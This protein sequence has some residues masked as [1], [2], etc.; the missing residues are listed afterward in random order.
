MTSNAYA[1]WEIKP[2]EHFNELA[3]QEKI[4]HLLKW[5]ILAANAHNAQVWRFQIHASESTL[6]IL[7]AQE[8]LLAKTDKDVRQS[9]TSLGCLTENIVLAAQCYGA[10]FELLNV[11]NREDLVDVILKKQSILKIKFHWANNTNSASAYKSVF[12]SES[13]KI[14]SAI[15]NRRSN[16]MKFDGRAVPEILLSSIKTKAQ[17]LNLQLFFVTD[18]PTRLAISELQYMADRTVVALPGFRDELLSHLISNTDL[19]SPRGMPGHTFGLSTES[20][21][22]LQTDL[23]MAGILNPDWAVGFA[24]AGRDG[25]RSAPTLVIACG[26]D[27]ISGWLS[28]G[29]L[30]QFAAVLAQTMGVSSAYNAA[31]VES[32]AL[33]AML[34]IRLGTFKKPICVF[35]LGYA[36]QEMKHSPR[37]PILDLTEVIL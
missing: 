20:T 26:E 10:F 17:E 18:T 7:L 14:F 11:Q 29:R 1:G 19:E 25:I 16:R 31:M 32:L 5:G 4:I 21:S 36:T 12:E 30:F 35:R 28:A 23:A 37:R 15:K 8:D 34:K 9:V 33:N 13:E 24:S 22:K 2:I 6:D 3:N 27:S